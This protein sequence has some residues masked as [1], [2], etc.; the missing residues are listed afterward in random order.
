MT[1]PTMLEMGRFERALLQAARAEIAPREALRKSAAALGVSL[2]VV[3]LAAFEVTMAGA[4]QA[5]GAVATTEAA[6]AG[7]VTSAQAGSAAFAMSTAGAA[8]AAGAASQP[9]ATATLIL[10][11]KHVGAGLVAG[12]LVAGGAHEASKAFGPAPAHRA[13]T[14][15]L[16]ETER[17]GAAAT[18]RRPATQLPPAA[19]PLE[20]AYDPAADEREDTTT[21]VAGDRIPLVYRSVPVGSL[22]EAHASEAAGFADAPAEPAEPNPQS[23]VVAAFPAEPVAKADQKTRLEAVPELVGLDLER[24]LIGRA[25]RALSHGRPLV[26]LRDLGA[27]AVKC[28]NGQLRAEANLLRIEALLRTGQRG[29]ALDVARQEIERNATRATVERVRDLFQAQG[30]PAEPSTASGASNRAGKSP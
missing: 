12:A 21:A 20:T 24:Q 5:T 10:L 30:D 8:G 6:T 28:R 9:L 14:P 7:V 23:A 13:D 22:R 29:T 2:P 18:H 3:G 16:T 19:P 15:A 4:A 27:Y 1:V 17:A 25:R 11:A 26:A